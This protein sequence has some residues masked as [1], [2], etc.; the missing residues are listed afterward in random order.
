MRVPRAAAFAAAVVLLGGASG[1]GLFGGGPGATA[2]AFA[3]A[4]SGGDDAA[5]AALTD[6]PAAAAELLAGVRV[7]LAPAALSVEVGQVRTAT[8]RALATVDVRWDLGADRLWSY[9]GELELRPAAQA[10]SGWS[11]RWSPSVVHPQLGE[12]QRLALRPEPAMPAPVLDRAGLPLLS[13][14][15]VITVLLDRRA[16]GDLATTAVT[17]ADALVSIDPSITVA[18]VVDGATATPDGQGYAV[19]VLRERDYDRVRDAIYDLPGVRFLRSERLLARDAGFGRQVLPAVRAEMAGTLD[20]VPGWA[21]LTV[22]SG[23]GVLR[24]LL[25]RAPQPGTGVATGLSLAAQIAAE[26][27]VAPLAQQAM[28]VAITPSTGQVLA[29]A[30][31]DAADAQGAVA[32]TGRYPPGSTFKIV[33]AEAGITQAGMS[34]AEPVACPAGVVVDGRRVPNAGGFDLGTVP[35]RTAFARSCN[36]TFAH[37]GAR[38]A[39]DALP[40]AA[41]TL[42]LG[43][44]FAVPGLVTVTGSVPVAQTEVLRAENAF[45]QGQVLASPFGMALVAAT[46]ARGAPVVPQLITDRPTEVLRAATAPDPTAV[47]QVRAMMRAVVTEGTATRLA[48]LGEVFGKTGTAEFAGDGRAHGWFV[49]YRGDVAFAVLVVD[50]GSSEVAVEVA[51]RF[52]RATG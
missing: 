22:D 32:L 7:A 33:T 43:A 29:I 20:G 38:L 5:A 34:A 44:D 2:E 42:G 41:L 21:V 6:D 15:Q 51:E 16:A 25:E 8:D 46:V 4:W 10:R 40:V 26:D 1:C 50:G 12:R 23:G 11:V 37:L 18:S 17:L 31:N 36:T 39:A 28:L 24:T 35:L 49:G 45:G 47:E 52:L 14:T 3:A 9:Q 19:A 27:A 13:A 48:G 30:Q